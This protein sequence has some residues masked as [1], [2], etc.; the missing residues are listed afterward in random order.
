MSR[1]T[2]FIVVPPD[3]PSTLSNQ[4]LSARA[5]NPGL[6]VVIPAPINLYTPSNRNWVLPLQFVFSFAWALEQ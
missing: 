4:S 5:A 2:G 6:Y 1:P 3:G